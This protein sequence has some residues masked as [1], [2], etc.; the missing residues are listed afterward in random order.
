M[1]KD[2]EPSKID[3][4]EL[5]LSYLHTIEQVSVTDRPGS[6]ERLTFRLFEI[7]NL[8]FPDILTRE[9]LKVANDKESGLRAVTED[10]INNE[11]TADR[12]KI[13][14]NAKYIVRES[15]PKNLISLNFKHKAIRVSCA[16]LVRMKINAEDKIKYF[17]LINWERKKAGNITL[18]PIGGGLKIKNINILKDFD[19]VAEKPESMDLRFT[20]SIARLDEFREWFY[21]RDA[22]NREIS[23]IN[24]IKEELVLES[25]LLS[26]S[27]WE[28]MKVH[29]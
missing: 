18:S 25:K 27:L 9:L 13:S 3:F 29:L 26:E 24:E 19:A 5:S 16:S 23:P 28:I 20:M 8:T 22:L 7:W 17:L 2:F 11:Q 15:R 10:E 6:F 14:E 4:S 21:L 12:I 1:I